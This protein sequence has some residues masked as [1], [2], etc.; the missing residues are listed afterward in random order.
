[1][2]TNKQIA[3]FKDDGFLILENAIDQ[4][5]LSSWQTEFWYTL[6][7][8][9]EDDETWPIDQTFISRWRFTP[10]YPNIATIPAVQ[11]AA[12][13]LGGE[14]FFGGGGAPII[15]WPS[16][17]ANWSMPMSSHIDGY[18]GPAQHPAG[19]LTL[20][21]TMY[22]HDVEEKG[23]GFIYW[24][25]THLNVHD[26][27]RERPEHIDGSF[28]DAD[29]WNHTK[30]SHGSKPVEFVAAAGT[31]LLWHGFLSHNGSTNVQNTPR[32]GIFGRWH[33]TKLQEMRYD[34]LD[35]LWKHWSI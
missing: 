6:G 34:I 15:K 25:G 9:F 22:L 13:D 27:F 16:Q 20:G 11:A 4:D 23:G 5:L 28:L 2:L 10:P 24:P 12:Y 1:M 19:G 32:I 31:V 29:D 17:K 35:D 21:A 14:N 26:Y 8:K 18:G 7:G 3:S 33:Y 30:F